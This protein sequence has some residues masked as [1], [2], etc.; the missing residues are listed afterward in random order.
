MGEFRQ[1]GGIHL[2]LP[3]EAISPMTRW[4]IA[5]RLRAAVTMHRITVIHAYGRRGARL[6]RAVSKATGVPFVASPI[7]NENHAPEHWVVPEMA[8]AS[9]IVA[10]SDFVAAL[11]PKALAAEAQIVIIPRGVDLTRFDPAAVRAE[12]LVRQMQ[13]W[14]SDDLSAVILMPGRVAPGKGHGILLQAMARMTNKQATCLIVARDDDDTKYRATLLKLIAQLGLEGRVRFVSHAP[15]M[16]VAYMLAD[17]VAVPSSTPEAF[18]SVCAEALAMGRPV[19]AS[20]VGGTPDLVIDGNTGWLVPPD[21]CDALSLALDQAL[22]LDA[23]A[24]VQLAEAC[25]GH[26]EA[27]CSLVGVRHRMLALYSSVTAPVRP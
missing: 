3:F 20:S 16:P 8:D 12:K 1:S 15:D 21:D 6:A 22:A 13:D 14:R 27:Q 18:N 17:V 11:V 23:A 26:I 7:A 2:A 4:R 5:R 9:A 19:V 25:R 24:R 10:A